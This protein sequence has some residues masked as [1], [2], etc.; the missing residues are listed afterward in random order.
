MKNNL[1]LIITDNYVY[2]CLKNQIYKEEITKDIVIH[3]RVAK[4]DSFYR[5]M[6]KIIKKNKLNDS[7]MGRNITVL[8][9]PNYLKSDKELLTS[10]LEKLSFNHIKFI[11]YNTLLEK[12]TLNVTA[13]YAILTEQEQSYFFDYHIFNDF[14]KSIV[15]L[16]KSNLKSSELFLIG[17]A[18]DLKQLG[19]KLEEQVP[20]KVFVYHN[21]DFYLIEKLNQIIA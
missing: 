20:I 16:I 15:I 1:G 19:I 21:S 18:S 17:D 3:N 14:L 8:E 12:P 7:L 11:T 2:L 9:F 13:N 6:Q 4:T 10:I 5:Y